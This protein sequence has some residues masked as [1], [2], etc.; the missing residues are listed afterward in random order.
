MLNLA[1]G[2]KLVTQDPGDEPASELLARKRDLPK[3]YVRRRKILKDTS[4]EAP[5][6]LFPDLPT[7]WTYAA[8]QQLYD[9]NVVID[10]ADGN[11]GSLYPRST[12]FREEGITFVSA[13]DLSDGRVEWGGCAKLNHNWASLLTKGWARSGDVLLTHNATVGRVALVTEDVEPFL[14]GTS[15]T[16]YRLDPNTLLPEFFFWVLQSSVWQGQLEA[17]MAQTT[18]NQVSIQKQAFFRVPVAPLAEQRRIVAKV[19]QLMEVCDR[20]EASLT[21]TVTTRRRLLDAL[22][23]EALAPTEARA[24]EA[25]E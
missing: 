25:A 3:G 14:L 5:D 12:E 6:D 19:D 13:K 1:V 8:I 17:I 21:A 11:H 4:I 9:L 7:S 18:R 22:L 16:F 2:G 24:L 23:A 10:Y 15:V 20:L